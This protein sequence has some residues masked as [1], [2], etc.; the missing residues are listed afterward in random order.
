MGLFNDSSASDSAKKAASIISKVHVPTLEEARAELEQYVQQGILTPE[1][2]QAMLQDETAFS[3]IQEDPSLRASQIDALNELSGIVDAGGMDARLRASLADVN[4]QQTAEARGQSDAIMDNARARGI[5]GSNLESVN[6]LVAQQGAATRAANQGVQAAALA[7]QRRMQ[8]LNDQAT[9]AGN[10]RNADYTRE[11]NEAQAR[12]TINRFNTAARQTAS[13]MNVRNANTAQAANL[14]EKQR[15]AD[16]NVRDANLVPQQIRDMQLN[17][18][19]AFAAAQNDIGAAKAGE[20]ASARQDIGNAFNLAGSAFMMSDERCKTDVEPFDADALL[21]DLS[22]VKFRYKDSV[23]GKP[24]AP[25]GQQ[26]GIF[27]QDL[28][29]HAPGAVQ[30]GP[31]GL[32]RVDTGQLGGIILAALSDIHDRLS[33]I[34][35]RGGAR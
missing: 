29:K 32:K 21:D 7:E 9:L 11:Q 15:L 5:G 19:K 6:R 8:A 12:D 2:A 35:G 18:A 26:V 13:D 1:Q 31:D 25:K 28:E 34:E 33:D 22:G 10:V 27:A 30:E 4:A 16:Q 20:N 24:G 3:Q 14:G 17:K 23:A